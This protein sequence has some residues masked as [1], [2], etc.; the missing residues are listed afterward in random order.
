MGELAAG[1]GWDFINTDSDTISMSSQRHDEDSVFDQHAASSNTCDSVSS[2]HNTP[3]EYA[4]PQP[5]WPCGEVSPMV[6]QESTT[7]ENNTNNNS[8]T[9]A[10]RR[11][12]NRTTRRKAAKENQSFVTTFPL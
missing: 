12:S 9:C 4:L 11:G 2:R 8:N 7:G 5:R 3:D 6:N 1:G 10:Q